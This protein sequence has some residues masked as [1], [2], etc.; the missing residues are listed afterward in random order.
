ML[1]DVIII[2]SGLGGVSA[3]AVLAQYGAK[4]LV[5]EANYL[6][7]G[8]LSSYWR[9]G[10]VFETGATTLM[11]YDPG[12]PLDFFEK[13]AGVSVEKIEINPSMTVFIDGAPLVRYKDRNQWID[14]AQR[15]FGNAKEQA[16]FWRL[17]LALSDFVWRVSGKNLH[18]PPASLS[19]WFQ[20]ARANKLAD[21]PYLRYAFVSAYDVA[22]TFRLHSDERFVRF[23][24]EQ[25]L[26][27]A[28]A[29][30]HD[31]PFLFAAPALCYTNYANYY[32]PGGMI[33]L[34][35]E[36]LAVAARNGGEILLRKKVTNVR[37]KDGI[38]EVMC[39]NGEKYSA[40]TILANV[41][42]WNLPEIVEG[43]LKQYF[44][45]EAA[46][47]TDY[48]GAFTIGLAVSDVFPPNNTLHQ[49]FILSEK[50]PF[51][52]A[53]SFFVSYSAR[54]DVARAPVGTRVLAISTHVEN[55]TQ[56]FSLTKEEYSHRKNKISET[57]I[58]YLRKNAPGF[59]ETVILYQLDS[60]PKSW[61][62]WTLRKNGTVGGLP[63]SMGRSL[64]SWQGACTPD[65]DFFL[66]GDT[67]YPGQGAPGV[68]LGGIIA[69]RRIFTR[70]KRQSF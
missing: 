25:L 4:T 16:R 5:L 30:A 38:Y 34:P 50:L 61:Q 66:C 36:A 47:F 26:I 49:Q 35:A 48:W 7:G 13:I 18:F 14:E 12:Q 23:L 9:K 67:V 45:K 27:T 55:P 43:D 62:D 63:Q 42:V 28:Q 69:A 8:C 31:T 46:R 70:L 53:G 65:E 24:D 44:A 15:F 20:T 21:L 52:N 51:C 19:D 11:G 56:W 37:K 32:L 17:A 41:P 59:A 54:G 68:T 29:T 40:K 3:A 22:K 57:I 39:Q 1:Y 10:Y 6:P 33:R 60:S 58:A 2:G 64:L